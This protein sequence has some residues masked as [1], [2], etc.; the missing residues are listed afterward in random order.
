MKQFSHARRPHVRPPKELLQATRTAH[1][2]LT[3]LAV[4]FGAGR[5]DHHAYLISR[6]SL[7]R[8]LTAGEL[9]FAAHCQARVLR[10]AAAD[11]HHRWA[12]SLRFRRAVI[13]ALLPDLDGTNPVEIRDALFG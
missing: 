11:F 12:T 7:D 1:E 13:R 2:Q 3:S 5:L 8:L 6:N 10:L 4:S 9:G